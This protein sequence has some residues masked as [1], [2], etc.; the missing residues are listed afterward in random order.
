MVKKIKKSEK[1]SFFENFK[2]WPLFIYL[3]VFAIYGN[4]LFNNYAL[5]DEFV[6]KHN[7]LVQQGIKSIPEI[8]ASPYYQSKETSFGYRPV[9]KAVFAIEYQIFGENPFVGHLINILL[10]T[11]TSVILFKLLLKIVLARTGPVFIFFVMLLWICHP[12]HTEV[13][14]S[15]KNREEILYLIFCL[16]SLSFFIRFIEQRK[17]Y[18][19]PAALALYVLAYFT[20]QSAI[21]FVL[22]IPMVLW[23][24]YIK[25]EPI[26]QMIKKNL[27]IFVIVMFLFI[28][29][30][31]LYKI[32]VWFFPAEKINLLSFENPLRFDNSKVSK[33]ALSAYAM[34]INIKL[35]FIPHPLVFYYGQFTI[36]VVRIS[37][38][39]VIFSLLFH[40]GMLFF[41]IKNLKSKS[42]LIFGIL[43]YFLGILPFS[44]YFMEIN[45]IVAE[46]FLYAPSIGFIIVLVYVLFKFTKTSIDTKLYSSA[47]KYLKFAFVGIV[48]LFTAKTI[49]RNSSWK[50]SM[51]L[52][53]NDIQYLENSVKANDILAQEL[54]DKVM[55]E[56]PLKKSFNQLK[57]TL[58]SIILLYNRTLELYPEN[59]KA[60]NNLANIYINFF[61]K[62]DIALT[63]L[64]KAY[65]LK[66][67]SFEVTLNI[68][69]CY[70]LIKKDTTA[71]RYYNYAI[72]ID[73]KQ[74]KS[75]QNLISLYYKMGLPDSSKAVCER[76][77]SRD[78]LTEIPY[79]GLGYYY[80]SKKDT[81]EA[82]K[83]WEK[84]VARN[85]Q[86]YER[87]ISLS[88][89]FK[90][91]DNA[92]KAKYYYQR[93]LQA[94]DNKQK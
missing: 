44:N 68:A 81:L 89:Y 92:E 59:P 63:Y 34:L 24:L 11:V 50:D 85:P 10:F 19:L 14:A 74:Y 4:T 15:L 37:D 56:M 27:N 55:R 2:K 90:L 29:T 83:N 41:T 16:L 26:G 51:T 32:P 62:P 43:F 66:K 91:H 17:W 36:P 77:L 22:I 69:Q 38:F 40:A 46:R 86:N 82:V 28:V 35:L 13:V 52:Y 58:D 65:E 93:A 7:K 78:T 25:I 1:I 39:F 8:F 49:A 61:N 53:S 87:L 73:P 30:F 88:K 18:F 75:W 3:T 64:K 94:K 48:L 76:M 79:V 70:E 54:M 60:L 47:S 20:K 72:D 33:L 84:A 71:I 5:D 42:V 21:A 67:G 57:P 23:F 45:G 9:T 80:I 12:I 31:I 6:I